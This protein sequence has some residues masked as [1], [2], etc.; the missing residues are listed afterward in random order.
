MSVR[1]FVL[2]IFVSV[3]FC[4]FTINV[5]FFPL[6]SFVVVALF[7]SN[8]LHLQDEGSTCTLQE[9]KR[10]NHIIFSSFSSFLFFVLFLTFPLVRLFPIIYSWHSILLKSVYSVMHDFVL[11]FHSL[12]VTACV[13]VRVCVSLCVVIIVPERQSVYLCMAIF[14]FYNHQLKKQNFG[15]CSLVFLWI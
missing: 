12:R 11:V 13:Y 6:S 10:S 2:G 3:L 7:K 8:V 14:I 5:F 4:N 9:S 15:K 1:Y